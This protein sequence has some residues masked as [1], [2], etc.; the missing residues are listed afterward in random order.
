MTAALLFAGAGCA[1]PTRGEHG[2]R[3]MVPKDMPLMPG[4][5]PLR[6]KDWTV[7]TEKDGR[8]RLESEWSADA[9]AK[10]IVDWYVGAFEIKHQASQTISKDGATRI[11]WGTPEQAYYGDTSVNQSIYVHER[12]EDG[13]TRVEMELDLPSR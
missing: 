11:F 13:R 10:A 2:D 6:E 8:R 12:R 1:V 5:E 3:S 9:D 4:L 7:R